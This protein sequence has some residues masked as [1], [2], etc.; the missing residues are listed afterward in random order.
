M[1][2]ETRDDAEPRSASEAKRGAISRGRGGCDRRGEVFVTPVDCFMRGTV[3]ELALL[4][5]RAGEEGAFEAALTSAI[6]LI[7]ATPGFVSLRVDRC[8]EKANRYAQ[9]VEWE[10]IEAHTEGFRGSD[11]YEDWRALLH[12]FYDPFPTVEHYRTI[13]RAGS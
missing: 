13:A 5:V 4:D 9:H 8:I 2:E 12:H 7:S 6:P 1:A 11:R 10:T 3:H